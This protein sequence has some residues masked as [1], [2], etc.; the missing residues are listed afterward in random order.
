MKHQSDVFAKNSTREMRQRA[1]LHASTPT[2]KPYRKLCAAAAAA[3]KILSSFT[4]AI[5]SINCSHEFHK[6]ED[7]FI[8][9]MLKKIWPN[10]HRIMEGFTQKIVTKL[11]KIWVWDPE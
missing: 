2:F 11:Y 5:I 9:E 10:F 6:I 7:Y 3:S 8:F 1:W 4:S